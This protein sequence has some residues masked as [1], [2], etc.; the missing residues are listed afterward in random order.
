MLNF[1]LKR[2]KSIVLTMAD[3]RAITL[4]FQINHGH[5][6][7]TMIGIEAPP[8]VRIKRESLPA[9]DVVRSMPSTPRGA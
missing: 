4:N 8:D 3:G 7:P 6:F 5:I 1:N 2:I 9:S